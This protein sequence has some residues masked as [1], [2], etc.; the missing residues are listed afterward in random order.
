MDNTNSP[1]PPPPDLL[2][3]YSTENVTA[4]LAPPPP[5]PIQG[6]YVM[7]GITYNTEDEIIQQLD[8]LGIRRLYP[9]PNTNFDRKHELKKLNH[10]ILA[11]FLDLLE[12]LI[13]CPSHTEKNRKMEDLKLLFI[14]MHHLLNEYRVHQARETLHLM[15]E[16]QVHERREIASRFGSHY[17]SAAVALQNCLNEI[18]NTLC[19]AV[20]IDS[21]RICTSSKIVAVKNED[22]GSTIS[23][24]RNSKLSC[25][26]TILT[27]LSDC[28]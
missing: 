6:H 2:K 15:L 3:M 25:I 19:N 12:I 9:G 21:Q 27:K 23:D 7:F 16:V 11:N 18:P 20:D 8:T 28:F 17:A 14:N 22:S 1:F 4:G 24:N 26:D 10:S 13:K 5:P